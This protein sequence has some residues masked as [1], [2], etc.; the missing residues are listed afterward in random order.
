MPR[1]ARSAGAAGFRVGVAARLQ[2]RP[3]ALDRRPRKPRPAQPPQPHAIPPAGDSGGSIIFN[4]GSSPV[5]S[6]DPI[7][8]N[9]SNDR[10]A[11][12]VSW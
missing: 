5:D 10:V 2:P 11:G 3:G 9:P 6:T 7:K 4:T 1:F 12:V 8:S